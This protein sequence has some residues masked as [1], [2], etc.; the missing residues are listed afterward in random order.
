M[1]AMVWIYRRIVSSR[2]LR[3]DH[4]QGVPAARH[5]RRR[6]ALAVPRHLR[7]LPRGGRD[8][9][10]ADDRVRLVPAPAARWPPRWSN[11][12]LANYATALSLD[13]VRSALWNSLLLGFATASIGVLLMGFLVVADLPLAAARRRRHRVPPDVPAGGAAPGLRLRDAVGVAGLPDPHLRHAVAP[14][15]R[16]PHG[17]PAARAADD[18]G[19]HPPDRPLARGVRPDVRRRRG[20]IGCAPSPCRCSGPG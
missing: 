1:F 4:R 15:D 3:H 13:A 2:D 6:P 9:A 12:T 14:A 16:L 7:R 8:P 20:A 5:G 19:R 11:F 17:V 10:R 18:L